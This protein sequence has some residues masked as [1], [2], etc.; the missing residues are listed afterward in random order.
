MNKSNNDSNSDK[1]KAESE[2]FQI[3]TVNKFH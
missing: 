3:I 1:V 2:I